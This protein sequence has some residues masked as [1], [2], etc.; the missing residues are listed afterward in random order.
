MAYSNNPNLPKARRWAVD[1]VLVHGYT[2]AQAARKAGVHRSTIGRWINL[3]IKLNLDSRNNIPTLSSAPRHHPNT[4]SEDVVT[5]IV[6]LRLKHG[7]C[8]EVIYHQCLSLDIKVSLSSVKRTLRR[9]ELIKKRSKWAR[10]RPHISRPIPSRPGSLIQIDTIHFFSYSPTKEIPTLCPKDKF[11]VYTAIDLNSRWAYAEYQPK[12]NQRVSLD[13][14]LRAQEQ[15]KKQSLGSNLK[16]SMIQTD[17]GLEFGHYYKDQLAA[18]GIKLRHSRVRQ[19]NDNAHIERFNRTIQ[20]EGFKTS[21]PT[22]HRVQSNIKQFLH[23]YNHDRIH[24]SINYKTPIQML[25]R[26]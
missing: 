3:H 9:Q 26:C 4:L 12:L 14:T 13:F 6:A 16:F 24:M 25:Q 11:Y 5:T 15:F 1:L 20:Q 10:Y 2:K 7:R 19:S 22:K 23:Y 18:K 8:A 21:H 17:N